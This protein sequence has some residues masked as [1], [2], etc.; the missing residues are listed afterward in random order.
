ME[1]IHVQTSKDT[2]DGQDT[3]LLLLE[4][5]FSHITNMTIQLLEDVDI[6][7]VIY[8]ELIV[9]EKARLS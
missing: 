7:T 4:C 1:C 9:T 3:L 6:M 2:L 8:P 5:E